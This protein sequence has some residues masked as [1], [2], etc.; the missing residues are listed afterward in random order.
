MASRDGKMVEGTDGTDHLFRERV[1]SQYAVS[2][3]N[4]SM[5]KLFL[6]AHW[7]VAGAQMLLLL[8]FLP[9]PLF[10]TSGLYLEHTWLA[11][12][13]FTILALM[14]C[15]KSKTGQMSVF[16]YAIIILGVLPSL[17]LI[18]ME[19]QDCLKYLTSGSTKDLSMWQGYPSAIISSG[20]SII[21]LLI[22]AGELKVAATL[23]EAW[24]PRHK[25]RT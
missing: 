5:L 2:A 10:P 14:A 1:A 11:S 18:G 3:K 15:N 25:K 23:L 9:F 17:A 8:P 7:L 19:S 21:N 24:A 16:R 12:L 22:H 13:P 20:L 4:K 6:F